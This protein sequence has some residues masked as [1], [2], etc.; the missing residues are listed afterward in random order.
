MKWWR[1]ATLAAIIFLSSSTAK[2]QDDW[3]NEIR[4]LELRLGEQQRQIDAQS[5]VIEAQQRRLDEQTRLAEIPARSSFESDQDRDRDEIEPAEL[6]IAPL[7]IAPRNV[8]NLRS[9]GEEGDA[10]ANPS[11]PSG[12]DFGYSNGFF[13]ASP[14]GVTHKDGTP[15]LLQVN[16]RLQLRHTAFDSQG[17]T[18]DENNLELER[19]RLVF[20]G[21]AFSPDFSYLAQLDGDT[22]DASTADFIDYALRYDFGHALLDLDAGSL[23]MRLGKYRLPFTRARQDSGFVLQFVDRATASDFFDVN[24]SIAVG[25]TGTGSVLDRPVAWEIALSNGIRDDGF[26]P[27]RTGGLDRN[28][29]Y[30]ARVSSELLGEWG[31]DGEPDLSWHERP[32]VKIGAAVAFTRVDRDDGFLEF[33]EIPAIGDSGVNPFVVDVVPATVD[34]FGVMLYAVDAN[35]KYRGLSMLGEYYFRQLTAFAGAPVTDRFDH[36][37]VLQTGYFLV[38]ERLE[39]AA[40]WS[41]MVGDSWTLGD[42][43][44][45]TDE[46][47]GG[48]TWYIRGHNLKLGFDVTHLNGS[49]IES[50]T[51]NV[52]AGDAGWLVRTQFQ[53]VF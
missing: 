39:V 2:A 30:A 8:R 19:A 12:L 6:L 15:F 31:T 22:D 18:S 26:T 32:A 46:V 41:R 11:R 4:R 49:P 42:A 47:A 43:E 21:Q 5:R 25:L 50:S 35:F 9:V 34:E 48:M 28:P 33:S 36:G 24:R 53:L 10:N 37:F 13:I 40:R 38:P 3:R 23:V 52:L 45:S 20:S 7:V 29:G 14:A 27:N 44:H 51:L 1:L 17:P 16:G